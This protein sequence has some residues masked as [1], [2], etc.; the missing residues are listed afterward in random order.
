VFIPALASFLP[1]RPTRCSTAQL[2]SMRSRS[3]QKR[4]SCHQRSSRRLRCP[5]AWPNSFTQQL[6]GCRRPNSS[7]GQAR[8]GHT[9]PATLCCEYN[10]IKVVPPITVQSQSAKISV[11]K[12]IL[13]SLSNRWARSSFYMGL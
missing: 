10:H 9:W 7:D 11:N 13:V 8:S 5:S 12:Q 3:W 4:V 1:S 6:G 2:A